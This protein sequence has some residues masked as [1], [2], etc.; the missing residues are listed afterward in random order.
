MRN[1]C[2]ILKCGLHLSG[3]TIHKMGDLHPYRAEYES[4]LGMP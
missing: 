2:N 3:R 1:A 4:C